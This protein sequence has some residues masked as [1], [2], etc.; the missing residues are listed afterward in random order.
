MNN[1]F[2]SNQIFYV[3]DIGYAR[4]F[5]DKNTKEDQKTKGNKVEVLP[6]IVKILSQAKQ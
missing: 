6:P 5:V 1:Q 4:I 3:K 2:Y